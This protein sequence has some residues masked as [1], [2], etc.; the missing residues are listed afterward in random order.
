MKHLG[1]ITKL[2]GSK[3]EPVN[4]IS[5]GSPC[6]DLSVAGKRAGLAGER[7]G[8][9]MEAVRVIKEMRVEDEKMEGQV[10]ILDQ[11]FC[12]GKMCQEPS[13]VT[14][15]KISE[16]CWKNLSESKNRELMFLDL[17]TKKEDLRSGENPVL[18]AAMIGVL[19]GELWTL[20][21]GESPSEEKESFLS[22]ILQG[23]APERFYLSA[24]ACQGILNRAEKRGKEL[25]EILKNALMSVIAKHSK[26][27]ADV[28]G[29]GKGPLIQD[30]KSA[31]L[32]TLQDQTL[33]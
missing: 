5:F 22:W 1:D 24:R 15:E 31:T 18:S 7:S 30:N 3:A 23:G 32:S 33:F 8:L 11:D 26:S 29:G 2:D 12:F 28:M 17:S 4:C 14:E 13:L 19:H 25:P 20:N 27:E 9:F 6:Q 21:T 10:S 16:P